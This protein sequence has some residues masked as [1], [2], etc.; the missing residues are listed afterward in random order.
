MIYFPHSSNER[1]CF[2]IECNNET[3]YCEQAMGLQP[4]PGRQL[5][6]GM[7]RAPD[8]ERIGFCPGRLRRGVDPSPAPE[9]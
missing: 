3:E 6:P 4:A 2:P 8:L 7:L 5:A 1:L 9:S